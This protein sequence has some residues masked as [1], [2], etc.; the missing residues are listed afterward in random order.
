MRAISPD[1]M[2]QSCA[3]VATLLSAWVDGEFDAAEGTHI[4][5]HLAVCAACARVARMQGEFKL[6][7][8][9]SAGS[10]PAAPLAL[11]EAVLARLDEAEE[12]IDGDGLDDGSPRA[13]WA[14]AFHRLT[15]RTVAFCA[16]AAGIA[17]W[18]IA[19]GLQHPLLTADSDRRAFAEATHVALDDGI[20]LHARALPLDYSASDAGSVQKWLQG[21]VEFGVRLP[22]FPRKNAPVLQ[23]VRLFTQ[24][25]RAAAVLTYIVP[26]AQGRRISLLVMD[27]PSPQLPG[28]ARRVDGREIWVAQARGYNVASWRSG[29]IVYS[30]ISDLEERDLIELLRTADLQ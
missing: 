9:R 14:R 19:G 24:H 26:A 4:E 20:A 15:P 7:L 17:A 30:L 8:R 5:G 23:G 12:D 11:R 1:A 2:T 10:V 28:I 6:A 16:A 13:L 21:R 22:R 29:E 25:S 27:G 18:L 3:E